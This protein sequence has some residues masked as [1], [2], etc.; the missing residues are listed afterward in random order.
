MFMCDCGKR[1]IA[2]VKALGGNGSSAAR[3]LSV[4]LLK[5][6]DL[7]DLTESG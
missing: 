1:S 4:F 2:G 6:K 7:P 3:D 5:N